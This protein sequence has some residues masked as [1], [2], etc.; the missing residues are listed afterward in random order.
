MT[1]RS[2][3][4]RVRKMKLERD[5]TEYKKVIILISYDILKKEINAI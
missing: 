4:L 1:A 3:T 5:Q 2:E